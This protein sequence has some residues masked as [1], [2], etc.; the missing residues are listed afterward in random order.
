MPD[1]VI[2]SRKF[3][4]RD[5]RGRNVDVVAQLGGY[6]SITSQHGAAHDEILAAAP[7]DI[8]EDIQALIAV[9][10][11]DPSGTPMH[12]IANA[13]YHLS[14]GK[15]DAAVA[16]LG[17]VV[18][19]EELYP[20]LGEA[21]RKAADPRLVDAYLETPK[22]KAVK[23]MNLIE[24]VK[25]RETSLSYSK[26][27]AEL[28][29]S[30]ASLVG[31]RKVDEP[32]IAAIAAGRFD[33]ATRTRVASSLKNK[34]FEEAVT[35]FVAARCRAAWD[36]RAAAAKSALDKP[37][38]RVAGRPPIVEDPTT[39]EGFIAKWGLE[40]EIGPA[41]RGDLGPQSVRWKLMIHGRDWRNAPDSDKVLWVDFTR[42][43]PTPPDLPMVLEALQNDFCSV[44]TYERDDWLMEF[45]FNADMK[46][47]RKG[48]VAYD[49]V[50]EAQI[51]A[52]KAIAGGDE[53]L[54]ELLT[55]V[56]D[57]PPID[58]EDYDAVAAKGLSPRL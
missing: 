15:I 47:L 7:D 10:L 27:R 37:H 49:Q 57:N 17:S 35:E 48:E 33:Q 39:F 2:N 6:F 24:R 4:L 34:V 55:S 43:N 45:G 44:M 31:K 50:L 32:E 41:R 13:A 52:F 40:L 22:A 26:E 36:A 1:R 56:G 14:E 42:G 5:A 54:R 3:L 28:T 29:E 51:P 11:C 53:G 12:G 25:L 9:H 58:V 23:L 18:R 16:S 46:T 21:T 8:R 20:V 19:P 38:Y 30:I